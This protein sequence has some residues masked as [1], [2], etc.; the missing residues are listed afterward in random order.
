M[1]YL[2]DTGVLLRIFDGEDPEYQIVQAMLKAIRRTGEELL[3]TSQ[4]ISEFWNV[5]TRPSTARGGYGKSIEATNRR[6][7]FIEHFGTIL[8]EPPE[9]YAEWRSLVLKHEVQGV[10]VHDARIVALMNVSKI[11]SII[12]LNRKDFTRYPWLN[13]FTPK[14]ALDSLAS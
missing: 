6:V 12:T 3:T 1:P 7:E 8:S 4:N 9:A 5:S 13:I 11:D 2:I 14:E 10:Q